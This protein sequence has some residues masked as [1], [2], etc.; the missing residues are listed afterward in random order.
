MR[1]ERS[2]ASFS[3][4]ISREEVRFEVFNIGKRQAGG[5]NESAKALYLDD[6]STVDNTFHL[7]GEVRLFVQISLYNMPWIRHIKLI[8]II[9]HALCPGLHF[10]C[11]CF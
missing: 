8:F 5:W 11:R 4:K 2:F 9:F 10:R 3:F 1:A 6:D 7:Q